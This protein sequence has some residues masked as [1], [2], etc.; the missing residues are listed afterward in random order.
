MM[1]P[2]TSVRRPPSENAQAAM[3][4]KAGFRNSEGWIATPAS[5]SQRR[6]PFTSAPKNSV[7]TTIASPTT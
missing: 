5:C 7:P 6:E 3:T 2:G 1:L 4:T